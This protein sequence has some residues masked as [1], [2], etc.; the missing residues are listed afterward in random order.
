MLNGGLKR[1]IDLF[2]LVTGITVWALF[3]LIV[4]FA[5]WVIAG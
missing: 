5:Q 1:K 3:F 4:G 2:I